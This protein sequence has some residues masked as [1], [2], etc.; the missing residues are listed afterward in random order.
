MAA[1]QTL[2]VKGFGVIR[3]GNVC[4][5]DASGG[6]WEPVGTQ[7]VVVHDCCCD[8]MVCRQYEN[9]NW[10]CLMA[11]DGTAMNDVWGGC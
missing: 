5:R 6:C 2:A 4:Y 10:R 8:E 11:T 7:M 9:E 3:S 1:H